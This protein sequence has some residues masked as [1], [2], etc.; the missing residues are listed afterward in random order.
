M[1]RKIGLPFLLMSL[2]VIA[3]PGGAFACIGVLSHSPSTRGGNGALGEENIS[4][5]EV[6]LCQERHSCQYFDVCC[7][8]GDMQFQGWACRSE[9][10]T[11]LAACSSEDQ[12]MTG[13]GRA[14]PNGRVLKDIAGYSIAI[15]LRIVLPLMML[16]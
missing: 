5:H 12:C 10:K 2:L 3:V 6:R 11:R 1:L 14:Y 13:S 4:Q 7:R 8:D 15:S 9:K 16:L